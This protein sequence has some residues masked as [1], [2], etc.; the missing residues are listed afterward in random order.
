M[1]RL[2]SSR[3]LSPLP[4]PNIISSQDLK[5]GHLNVRSYLAKWEDILIDKHIAHTDVMCFTE[6]FLQPHQHVHNLSLNHS[7]SVL[8]RCDRP[9]GQGLSNG[10]VMIACASNLQPHITPLEQH[11]SLEA[12]AVEV[13]NGQLYIIA[14]YRRPQLPLNRFL[15]MLKDYLRQLP[16]SSKPTIILGDFNENL[17]LPLVLS[18]LCTLV[19]T[20]FQSVGD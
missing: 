8:F 12:V 17:L 16:H 13:N 2:A 1:E 7:S 9:A 20:W 6:T 18:P 15:S 19:N 11:T 14:V 4:V 3:V 10:G 5:I